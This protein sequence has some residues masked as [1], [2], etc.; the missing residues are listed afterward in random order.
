LPALLSKCSDHD[1]ELGEYVLGNPVRDIAARVT[2]TWDPGM[3]FGR[4]PAARYTT[5]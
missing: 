1:K 4:I 5:V 3:D 2:S